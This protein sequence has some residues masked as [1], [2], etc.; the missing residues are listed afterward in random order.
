M[1]S[2]KDPKQ[3]SLPVVT[4][5]PGK[6][7]VARSRM[8]PLR[9]GVLL[10][11]QLLIIAH[12]IQW[13]ATGTTLAPIE[14][15]ES[16][17][18]VQYGIITVGFI[19][20]VL[21][22]ASTAILGRWFCGWGCHVLLLQ[23]ASTKLLNRMGLKPKPFRSRLLMMVPLI[24]ATYMFIWPL[25]Y[26]FIIAKLFG[27]DLIWPGFTLHLT[28]TSFWKTFPGLMVAIP[29]LL[30]C[31][32]LIVY[33]LGMKGYC[34]YACPYGGFFAPIEQVA[35]G[36][37]R[38]TDDCEQCGHC[39]AVCTSNVR[40]HEEVHDF[41]MV[42][43]QGCMKCMDCV[44]VC[45]N[46]ALYFGFGKAAVNKPES[47]RPKRKWDLSWPEEIVFALI[48]LACFLSV[49][50]AYGLIPLLFASGITAIVVF[51][52]WKAWCCLK[53]T[54]V[55]LH[56]MQLK[57]SGRIRPAGGGLLAITA[58]M[59]LL[60]V[61][62]GVVTGAQMIAQYH[63]GKVTIP[64][65]TV[66]TRNAM[67]P[68]QKIID[69]ARKARYWFKLSSYIGD[70]GIGLA[71]PMQA[72]TDNRLG[73]LHSVEQQLDE[74]EQVM[75]RSIERYGL[76]E[77]NAAGIGRILNTQGRTEEAEQ[78][79]RASS[80]EL[81]QSFSL[82]EE[83]VMV[84][85]QSGRSR[86]AIGFLDE[87]LADTPPDIR[88]WLDQEG[89][90][91]PTLVEKVREI[92]SQQ[93]WILGAIQRLSVL[94]IN[95]P[96]SPEELNEGV[97]LVERTTEADPDNPF[98]YRVLALGYARQDRLNDAVSAVRNSIRL[99]PNE[100]VFRQQLVELLNAM[101]RTDEARAVMNEA[102]QLQKQ[103]QQSQPTP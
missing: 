73:W 33:L 2:E 71:W 58:F 25:F 49:R 35:K 68:Q 60:V 66:F 76:S 30:V 97:E 12:V 88:L 8:S 67:I 103:L 44:S 82:L 40:V 26:R 84:L 98:A 3:I 102:Q 85:D 62:T 86:E 27:P 9:F 54:N 1:N 11:V 10:L 101:G 55:R 15:S 6:K 16:I 20:F 34:T 42:V 79:Y 36:R 14:P 91:A 50:G 41:K 95:S 61:H 99:E 75:R 52:S 48:A 56:S 21:A 74:A 69:H 57:R 72:A 45:P 32:F 81:P 18:T 92:I 31:G 5:A 63:D 65:Y 70:G 29:F 83:Y 94:L 7:S 90:S 77:H 22:L 24:L 17:E 59:L 37:I 19:F 23:D 38:V 28:T 78:W 96:Q 89:S 64:T 13:M 39:T 87:R 43:D 47:N 4:Q 100:I 93:P 53:K 80:L 46:D 51:M